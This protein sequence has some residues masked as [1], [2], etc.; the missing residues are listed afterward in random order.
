MNTNTTQTQR[1][2]WAQQSAESYREL[3]HRN[4]PQIDREWAAQKAATYEALGAMLEADPK[5][6]YTLM[7]SGAFNDL[8]KAY[9]ELAMIRAGIPEDTFFDVLAKMSGAFDEYGAEEA[10]KRTGRML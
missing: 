10:L 3:L 7:D 2:N 4:D 8:C 6:L 9:A 1:K 5:A